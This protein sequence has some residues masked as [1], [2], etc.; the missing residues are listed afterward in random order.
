MGGSSAFESHWQH[1]TVKSSLCA[2]PVFTRGSIWLWVSLTT[3]NSEEFTLYSASVD[4]GGSIVS[5][6]WVN[7]QLKFPYI[8]LLVDCFKWA[9]IDNIE[10]WKV[11]SV[12]WQ[13]QMG[14]SI[15]SFIWVKLT[16]KI[17]LYFLIS[18]L[19]RMGSHWHYWIAKSSLCALAVLNGGP[20][21]VLPPWGKSENLSSQTFRCAHQKGLFTLCKTNHIWIR[22]LISNQL[23]GIWFSNWSAIY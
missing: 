1:W 20:S 22:Q 16:T 8:F 2:L 9:P 21:S 19:F 15:I 4:H 12:L 3:L 23:I 18:W 10:P 6:T 14:W 5:F 17:S 7:W 11:H 13:F